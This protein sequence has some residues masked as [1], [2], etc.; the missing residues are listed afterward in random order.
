MAE[1]IEVTA[2]TDLALLRAGLRT[3]PVGAAYLLGDLD[4]PYFRSCRWFV[5]TY[6]GRPLAVVMLFE[7]LSV[8]ALLSYGAPDAVAVALRKCGEELPAECYAKVP[9]EHREALAERFRIVES[10]TFWT[11]GLEPGDF[12]RESTAE[13]IRQLDSEDLA[14][15]LALYDA[16]PG[17]FFEPGQLEHG[18]YFGR[19]CAGELVTIAGT[20]VFSSRERVAVLGN[21]VTAREHRGRGHARVCTSRL[22]EVLGE[23]GCRT[24]ALQVA[25]RNAPAISC[26]R[27]LGFRFHSATLQ[28]RCMRR[29][30]PG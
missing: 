27:R 15:M 26:Y 23:R 10:E 3:D 20:H 11:M 8:P 16:Y 25:E 18:L 17:H 1:R 13:G 14:A 7:G 4:D 21:L 12:Q 30:S 2:T 28:A 24:V 22:I 19:F 6:R 29:N 5:A 9:L